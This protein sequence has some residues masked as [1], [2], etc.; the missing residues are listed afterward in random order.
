MDLQQK[1]NSGDAAKTAKTATLPET[2]GSSDNDDPPEIAVQ[3]PLTWAE[4]PKRCPAAFCSDFLPRI[5]VPKILAMFN[6]ERDLKEE[7][8]K[9]PKAK[10][11]HLLHL[12]LCHAITVEKRRKYFTKLGEQRRWPIILDLEDVFLR[13]FKLQDKIMELFE[14]P[15]KL[16]SCPIWA[17]FLVSIDYNIFDFA[18]SDSKT[19]FPAAITGKRC[20]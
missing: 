15:H 16:V 10:G 12:E 5:E 1:L 4:L 11:L 14:K 2:A 3:A 6:R 8:H 7:L 17:N 20:G 9:N 19:G 13:V 18:D